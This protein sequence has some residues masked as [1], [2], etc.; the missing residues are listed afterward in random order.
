MAEEDQDKNKKAV[1]VKYEFED[2]APRVK[3]SGRGIIAERILE[4]AKNNNIPI[5]EDPALVEV[6]S[7]LELDSLIPPE[8]YQVVAEILAYVYRLDRE[9]AA[10]GSSPALR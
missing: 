3:A 4:V 8:L 2:L 5:V 7:R 10:R 1:A 6:L 9:M